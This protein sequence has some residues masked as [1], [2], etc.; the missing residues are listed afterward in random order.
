MI[1]RYTCR[2]LAFDSRQGQIKIT[3]FGL[4]KQLEDVS[5]AS[6][7]LTSQGAG[8]IWYLPP[9]CFESVSPRISP[10]VDVWS[11]GVVL[12]Q[13][14]YGKKPFGNDMSQR[15]LLSSNVIKS[16]MKVEFPQKPPIPPELKV[17]PIHFS[18]SWSHIS[19]LH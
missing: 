1:L 4:S 9:E 16:D 15:G 2:L 17:S 14:V 10:K 5:S 3:D 19:E 8:T 6:V 18:L 12:Y 13:M 7:D 11:M